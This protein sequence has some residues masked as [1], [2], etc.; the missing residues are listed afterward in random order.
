MEGPRIRFTAAFLPRLFLL[1]ALPALAQEAQI[2]TLPAETTWA[3]AFLGKDQDANKSVVAVDA[4]FTAPTADKPGRL[5]VTA[6][7]EPG[8]HIYSITQ[9]TSED[10]QPDGHEDRGQAAGRGSP[11]GP[12]QAV[13]RPRKRHGAR[14]LRRSADRNPRGHGHLVRADRTGRRRGSG[15]AQDHGNLFVRGVRRQQLPP[16]AGLAVYGRAWTRG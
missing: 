10:G 12:V 6:T 16:A 3:A 2:G 9:P 1:A 14:S 13:G 15:E 8:W 11:V 5:F 4:Q 7:I